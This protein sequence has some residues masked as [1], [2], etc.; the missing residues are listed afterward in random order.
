M[1]CGSGMKAIEL[2]YYNILANKDKC[3]VA[4]GMEKND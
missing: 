2:A 4:G 1:V 3:I